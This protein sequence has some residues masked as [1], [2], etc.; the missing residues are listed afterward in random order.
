MITSIGEYENISS[1]VESLEGALDEYI[2]IKALFKDREGHNQR[3]WS[4]VRNTYVNTGEIEIEDMENCN[5]SQRY[6][7]NEVK[8][9]IKNNK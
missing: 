7:I 8:L 2:A 6:F 3:E 9:V 5:K 1:E 4:R